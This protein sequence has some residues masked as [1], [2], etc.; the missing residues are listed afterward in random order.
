MGIDKSLKTKGK[1]VRP[2]NVFSRIERI[3]MLKG[4]GKWDPTMSVFG[5]P[6]VKALKVKRKA[7]EKKAAKA[8]ATA[9]ATP[10]TAGAAGKAE[11][12]PAAEKEKTKK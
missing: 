12:A 1:L 2:R 3:K 10:T 5:I 4:E 6:K 11:A 9:E 7:K 8:E